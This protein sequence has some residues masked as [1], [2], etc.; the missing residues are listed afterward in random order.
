MWETVHVQLAI[1]Q[2]WQLPDELSIVETYV[3][4]MRVR[5]SWQATKYPDDMVLAAWRKKLQ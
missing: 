1:T 2:G 5:P 4:A 3:D